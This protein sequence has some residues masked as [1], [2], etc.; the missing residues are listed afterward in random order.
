MLSD[1]PD[2]R[3]MIKV[4]SC[5]TGQGQSEVCVEPKRWKLGSCETCSSSLPPLWLGFQ[6]SAATSFSIQYTTIYMS[7]PPKVQL[8][9]NNTG[10]CIQPRHSIPSHDYHG[11]VPLPINFSYFSTVETLAKVSGDSRPQQSAVFTRSVVARN[12]TRS[13]NR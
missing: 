13:C 5:R 1:A 11:G 12:C 8:M 9:V 3:E 6:R 2:L 7:T 10:T 4:S